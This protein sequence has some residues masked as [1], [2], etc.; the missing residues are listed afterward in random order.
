MRWIPGLAAASVALSMGCGNGGQSEE[1]SASMA[2][3]DDPDTSA[4]AGPTT[5]VE[6]E[7]GP[8]GTTSDDGPDPTM[9]V[10]TQPEPV[11]GNG[12][13]ESIEEC[14]DGNQVDGDGCDADCTLNLDT[15]LWQ[16]THAGD[17]GVRDGGH[18]IAV[19]GAGN[20]VVGGYEVDAIGDPNMW[21]AKYAPD[22]TELW[23]T[24][25]DPSGGLDDR[26]YGVAIDPMDN[27]VVV[28]DVDVAPSSSDVWVAKLDGNGGE[29]WSAT[30]DGPDAGDDGGR[31]VA[32]DS[33]G[34]VI[35]VGFQ[36]VANN[37]VDIFVVAL[38]AGGATQWSELVP[39]PKTLDD[40]ATGVAVN[41]SDEIV[42]SGYVSNGGFNRDVWLRKYDA[43][44]GEQWTEIWDSANS[45]D[46]VGWGVAIAPDG[47]IAV[48]GM[49]PVIADNQ[50]V[51]LGRFDGDGMLLWW[52]QFGGQAYVDDTG[53]A[54]TADGDGN[55]VVAGFRG[56]SPSDTDIWLRK[57]DEGGNVLWSQ[58][59]E[60][61]AGDR[62]EATAIAAEA[63]G[64]LVV[65][66]EIRNGVGNDG[67]I[68][69]GRFGPG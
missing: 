57:Y 54:V 27:I 9:G 1:A 52:K 2:T 50:D 69:I 17:A 10:T 29:L 6:D 4:S 7:T 30:F 19:D 45:G 8:P 33:A 61:S 34:N 64:T 48:A 20:I 68:W 39:G 38:S 55:L 15:S 14:D 66:G 63:D 44:G 60:G 56:A 59:V 53:L 37:D 62:D 35:A 58:V 13:L 21:L 43:G 5:A 12:I 67:D 18:G 24:T 22:G 3:S 23:A 65:T 36:R 49:T 11:C 42:V 51:W 26:I 40:R 16:T 41:G 46:D 47:S 32:C 31:G 28:G 25:Y